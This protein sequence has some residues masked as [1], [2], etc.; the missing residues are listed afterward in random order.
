MTPRRPRL[1]FAVA[2]A[3]VTLGPGCSPPPPRTRAPARLDLAGLRQAHGR[4]AELRQRHAAQAGVYL[5]VDD[6]LRHEGVAGELTL[7]HLRVRRY[8]ILDPGHDE[9]G[10]FTLRLRP[11]ERLASVALATLTPDGRTT[12]FGARDLVTERH[13][14]GYTVVKLA[15]PRVVPGTLVEER[16]EVQL[17]YRRETRHLLR[18][19]SVLLQREQPIERLRL[20]YWA[21]ISHGV[22]VRPSPGLAA[23]RLRRHDGTPGYHHWSIQATHVPGVPAEPLT[24]PLGAEIA[25]VRFYVPWLPPDDETTGVTPTW[26]GLGG[27]LGELLRPDQALRERMGMLVAHL[28]G[29]A[30]RNRD[31]ASEALVWA[32]RWWSPAPEG[33]EP[34]TLAQAFEA[35]HGSRLQL[36][37]VMVH[38]LR[39]LGLSAEIVMVHDARDGPFDVRFPSL[40]EVDLP[41]VSVN[42]DGRGVLLVPWIQAMPLDLLPPY[43]QGQQALRVGPEGFRGFFR[44][45]VRDES[46]ASREARFD[47][48]LAGPTDLAVS[49]TETY[50][51]LLAAPLREL[52]QGRSPADRLRY[53]RRRLL[54]FGA[55][56][57]GREVQVVG[58]ETPEAPLVLRS[59]YTVPGA[60]ATTP[61]GRVLRLS[62][63]RVLPFTLV[64]GRKRPLWIELSRRDVEHVT[65]HLPPGYGVLSQ[66]APRVQETRLGAVRRTVRLAGGVLHVSNE[67]LLR[68]GQLPPEAQGGMRDVFDLADDLS[69]VTVVLTPDASALRP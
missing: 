39:A 58:L 54:G 14:Q 66:P 35:R 37:A 27:M 30:E 47:V 67:I 52:L 13:G 69:D 51:G 10:T 45:A 57:P 43:L 3:L 38:L 65:V 64:P 50:R 62:T 46:S 33:Q 32:Q 68:R 4:L 9:L 24:P 12:Q 29:R 11:G 26:Q 16:T 6:D 31:L 48:R 63:G 17:P 56:A 7:R 22:M 1:G 44:T 61:L 25:W 2:L 21:P 23:E 18:T 41:V 19:Q 55:A 53:L 5:L 34:D 40:L 28:G 60:V 15:Y 20:A 8:L 49:L 42:L 59:R 36:A